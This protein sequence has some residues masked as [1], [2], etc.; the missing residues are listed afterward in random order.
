MFVLMRRT[1]SFHQKAFWL[2]VSYFA[3]FV[4]S[5]IFCCS[6]NYSIPDSESAKGAESDTLAMNCCRAKLE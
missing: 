6:Q 5:E 4:F 2:S 3:K 1:G